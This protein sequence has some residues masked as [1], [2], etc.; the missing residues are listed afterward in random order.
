[1][2]E[3]NRER[4]LKA[5]T[6]IDKAISIMEEITGPSWGDLELIEEM[7]KARAVLVEIAEGT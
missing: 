6:E 1:M 5:I 7:K 2:N 3:A 4:I